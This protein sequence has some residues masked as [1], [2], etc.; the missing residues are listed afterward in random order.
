MVMAFLMPHPLFA[1]NGDLSRGDESGT[2]D[3]EFIEHSTAVIPFQENYGSSGSESSLD[4]RETSRLQADPSRQPQRSS[5][6]PKLTGGDLSIEGLLSQANP[7]NVEHFHWANICRPGLLPAVRFNTPLVVPWNDS[8][9]GRNIYSTFLTRS[10]NL[11]RCLPVS[12]TY[13]PCI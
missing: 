2:D 12:R 6:S 10:G 13:A 9:R 5:D 1:S 8:F 7:Q 3:D 4:E 11:Q